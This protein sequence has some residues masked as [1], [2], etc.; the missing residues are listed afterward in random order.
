MSESIV[1]PWQE[2]AEFYGKVL[3]ELASPTF[4][5]EPCR[6]PSK[7]HFEWRVMRVGEAPEKID[8]IGI[9]TDHILDMNGMAEAQQKKYLRNTFK[10]KFDDL[11]RKLGL[12]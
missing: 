9:G 2:R 8:I 1:L 3:G 11:R 5:L 4:F 6:Y 7:E 12:G 10:H